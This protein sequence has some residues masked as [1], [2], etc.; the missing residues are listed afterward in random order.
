MK[1]LNT[2]LTALILIVSN[3]G[4]FGQMNHLY[5]R[6]L[7]SYSD[8]VYPVLSEQ[9]VFMFSYQNYWPEVPSAFNVVSAQTQLYFDYFS[10]AFTF[11]AQN[12][13]QAGASIKSY[14]IHGAYAQAIRVGPK[15]RIAVSILA[16]LNKHSFQF[17][18][19][20]GERSVEL[21]NSYASAFYPDISFSLAWQYSNSL[22]LFSY[23]NLLDTEGGPLTIDANKV[24]TLYYSQLV[25][26]TRTIGVKPFMELNQL[27]ELTYGTLGSE[28]TYSSLSSYL[29]LTGGGE[30]L[31]GN[32][33]FGLGYQ[34]KN[35][36][37]HYVYL[38]VLNNYNLAEGRNGAHEVTFLYNLQYNGKRKKIRAIKCPDF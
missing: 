28:L 33:R 15:S 10:G 14:N 25:K 9:S 20:D 27:P 18:Q 3:L 11:G 8:P 35:H 37:F 13:Y 23:K 6:V 38:A 31:I 12:E 29:S 32:L 16:S 1:L 21:T 17:D 4:A 22:T 7:N 24:L 30:N 19:I 26:V 34:L 36:Q 5:N 2:I